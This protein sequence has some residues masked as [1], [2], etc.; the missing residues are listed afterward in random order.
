MKWTELRFKEQEEKDYLLFQ[1]VVMSYRNTF[2][3]VY[4]AETYGTIVDAA[5]L[6]STGGT[7]LIE[8]KQRSA[9]ALTYFDCFIE[10]GK[11]HRMMTEWRERGLSPYY[12][13]FFGEEEHPVVYIWKLNDIRDNLRFY[14]N[15]EIKN[16]D[17]NLECVDRIGLAWNQ[18]LRLEWDDCRG[19]YVAV[20]K[21]SVEGSAP[22]YMDRN[23]FETILE[24]I[25]K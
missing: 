22:L 11:W 18:G 1:Q 7:M 19:K 6:N 16:A 2:A 8:L 25:L 23:K 3:E 9:K 21:P 24:K 5:A 13:N 10:S 12:I 14:P 15:V 20:K 17:G 4:K